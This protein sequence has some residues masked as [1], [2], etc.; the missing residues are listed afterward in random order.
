MALQMKLTTELDKLLEATDA[1]LV[2][3]TRGDHF[4]GICRAENHLG[5]SRTLSIQ[6]TKEDTVLLRCK[7]KCLDHEIYEWLKNFGQRVTMHDTAEPFVKIPKAVLNSLGR[8]LG[9]INPL[10]DVKLSKTR[11]KAND[12][13]IYAAQRSYSNEA[14]KGPSFPLLSK[15]MWNT[16]LSKSAVTRARRTLVA[17]GFMIPEYRVKP[18]A[19]FREGPNQF[20]EFNTQEEVIKYIGLN[21]GAEQ[22]STSF[23]FPEVQ[24]NTRDNIMPDTTNVPSTP[25]DEPATLPP[26]KESKLKLKNQTH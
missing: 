16:G 9:S 11:F 23:R 18:P 14:K 7:K 26:Q 3:P 15:L 24:L 10:V 12:L 5:K 25:F 13:A 1:S 22:S 2:D 4:M 6:L 21:P 20:V 19:R 8:T 17:T